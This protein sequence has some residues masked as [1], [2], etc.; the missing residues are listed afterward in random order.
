MSWKAFKD[1]CPG[2]QP[3]LLDATTGQLLPSDSVEMQAVSRVWTQT[4]LAE[5]EAFHRFTCLNSRTTEDLRLVQDLQEK[6]GQAIA[7]I[8]PNIFKQKL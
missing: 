6:M 4:T 8:P 5:R 1:D 2:C 3:A 7:D